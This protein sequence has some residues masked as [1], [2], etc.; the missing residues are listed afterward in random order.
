M[1][2]FDYFKTDFYRMTGTPFK[3]DLK[4]LVLIAASH[5]IRYMYWWRKYNQKHSFFSKYKLYRY[6]RKYGLEISGNAQIGKGLYLGHPYNITVGSD[7]TIG[8]N[9][10]LHKGCTIGRENRGKRIGSPQLGNN[11]YVGINATI[12]GN[13]CI[14]NNVMIAPNSFVNFDVPD[15]SIV[16]GNPGVIHQSEQAIDSYIGFRY[17]AKQ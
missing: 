11:I 12:V 7:V 10:N 5:Q 8:D 13:V 15:N 16:I 14:G 9:V 1:S 2:A 3:F 17:E 4:C 6:G